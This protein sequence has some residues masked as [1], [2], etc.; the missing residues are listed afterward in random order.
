MLYLCAAAAFSLF[1]FPFSSVHAQGVQTGFASFY[2]KRMTGARTASGD[3]LHHD[4]LTCAHRSHP[5]GT[6]LRVKCLDNGREVVVRVNDR[7]PFVRGRIIDLS[8]G[9]AREL[10]ILMQGLARVSVEPIGPLQY[11]VLQIDPLHE[12]VE[13]PTLYETLE[14]EEMPLFLQN[15][16]GMKE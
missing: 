15:G 8:W 5:F 3:K 11:V 16:I 10:G 7:G 12:K 1:T 13:L 6:L 9:A 4:S 2:A 14:A